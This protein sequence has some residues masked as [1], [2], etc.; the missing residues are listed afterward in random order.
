MFTEAILF[1]FMVATIF[2]M[3]LLRKRID[4]LEDK[5]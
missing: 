2:N 4:K 5:K 1:I 3:S